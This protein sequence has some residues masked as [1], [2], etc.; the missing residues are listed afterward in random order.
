M[1]G[2]T[3]RIVFQPLPQEP[4]SPSAGHRA[5]KVDARLEPEGRL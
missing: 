4:D 2:S 1:T 5:R 3:L